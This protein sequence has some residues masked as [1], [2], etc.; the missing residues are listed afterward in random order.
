MYIIIIIIITLSILSPFSHRPDI[1]RLGLGV[2]HQF[3][4]PF[5]LSVPSLCRYRH[6]V[7]SDHPSFTLHPV[8]T[9]TLSVPPPCQYLHPVTEYLDLVSTLPCQY[10]S[11]C[12]CRHLV[13]TLPCQCPV[14][15]SVALTSN[16]TSFVLS[17]PCD[18]LFSPENESVMFSLLGKELELKVYLFLTT[19]LFPRRRMYSYFHSPALK[20]LRSF[21][22]IFR[23]LPVKELKRGASVGLPPTMR[24]RSLCVEP[25]T[26]CDGLT[27]RRWLRWGSASAGHGHELETSCCLPSFL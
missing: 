18:S 8:S 20:G 2:K 14:S 6:L 3:T 13:S 5:S 9:F 4:S 27:G 10:H 16:H 21:C 1:T 15:T 7:T 17:A 24:M 25:V 19:R 12:Q 22:W 26:C 23:A 11:P